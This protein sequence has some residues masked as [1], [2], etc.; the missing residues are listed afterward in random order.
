MRRVP[1]SLVVLLGACSDDPDE[2]WEGLW[3]GDELCACAEAQPAEGKKLPVEV[4]V[5]RGEQPVFEGR[6]VC[7]T[8]AQHVLA[9]R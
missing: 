5:R 3:V 2:G 6:F 9:E 7:F 4:V 8:P 1:L